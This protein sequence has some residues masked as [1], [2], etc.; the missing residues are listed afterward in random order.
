M[1]VGMILEREELLDR[2]SDDLAAAA[3]G[4]GSFA[5]VS[6][7]A[8][9][10]KTTA[11]NEFARTAP[12]NTLVLYGFCDPLSTPRPLGPLIDIANDP[13]S[14]LE[15][16]LEH[17]DLFEMF[18]AVHARLQHTIRP[19]LMVI[20]DVHWADAATLDM[21]TFLARRIGDTRA[22][23]VATYRGDEITPDHPLRPVLADLGSKPNVHRY[24]VEPLSLD[25]IETLAAGHDVD[26]QRIFDVTGGNAFY[27]TELLGAE[28]TV[29]ETVQDAVLA[30]VS[31]L[32]AEARQAVEAVSVA[33]RSMEL[34]QI[35]SLTGVDPAAPERAVHRGVLIG[36]S[37]GYR[38]R[39][40]LAR[41]A[42]EES[43]PQPRRVGLHTTVL[44]QIADS[45]DLSRL[46]HH[47]IESDNQDAI[48][49]HVPAAAREATRRSAHHQ[50]VG[51]YEAAHP[52][53]KSMD[54]EDRF[55][56]LVGY[57]ESLRIIN[58][59]A[60][61]L[62]VAN[63]LVELAE[64]N[65]V[66]RFLGVALRIRG[67]ALWMNGDA[68]ASNTDMEESIAVLD[69]LGPSPDLSD[70]L[71]WAA[72]NHMLDRHYAS[73]MRLAKRAVEVAGAIGSTTHE[74]K[75]LQTMGTIELV[76]GEATRGITLI[77]RSI[78]LGKS[79]SDR[80]VGVVGYE[81]LGT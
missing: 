26:S 51:L 80:R 31:L 66:A 39:H 14:G 74:V 65:T 55:R 8:G 41:L 29:P 42:I 32:D 71:D 54:P 45:G 28:G 75:S 43:I 15:E 9:A 46:A 67:K 12:R 48:L 13:G 16:V 36:D 73:G 20:E 21:L 70:S 47:A 37:S 44:Q 18:V 69:A 79:S 53:A 68:A 62:A 56:F 34:A 10:G 77:E 5:F 81:M 24:P 33:P 72:S 64:A 25:A 4:S 7:E 78:E 30:R 27:V 11:V 76:M 40:E 58:R 23:I 2:L 35:V 3:G 57:T 59:P 60:D 49:R 17:S 38:F 52:F 22:L 1:P 61:S 19:I 6:G 50:A 63:E